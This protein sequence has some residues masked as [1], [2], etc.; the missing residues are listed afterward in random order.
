MENIFENRMPMALRDISGISYRVSLS[1]LVFVEVKDKYC[2]F[3][4]RGIGNELKIRMSMGEISL[5][6]QFVRIDRSHIVNVWHV[7]KFNAAYVW[8]KWN[9]SVI[10]LPCTCSHFDLSFADWREALTVN[11]R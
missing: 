11:N 1:E 6:A 8:V 10:Q 9:G 2:L 4:F 5:P 3:H 7:E